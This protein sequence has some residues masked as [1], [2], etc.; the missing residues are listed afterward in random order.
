[1]SISLKNHEDR[2]KALENKTQLF[3][4]ADGTFDEMCELLV[5]IPSNAINLFLAITIGGIGQ[6]GIPSDDRY[7]RWFVPLMYLT[8][9][10]HQNKIKIYEGALISWPKKDVNGWHAYRIIEDGDE[11]HD[12]YYQLIAELKIYYIFRYNIYK[13]LKLISPIL[14]F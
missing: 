3:K 9:Y 6:S 7:D 8:E 10:K 1:M 13:I 11:S 12:N 5:Y 2:I 14:K 4:V